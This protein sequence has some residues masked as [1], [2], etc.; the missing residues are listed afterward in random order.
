MSTART[1]TENLLAET[2]DVERERGPEGFGPHE[3]NMQRANVTGMAGV[4]K[5]HRTPLTFILMNVWTFP[6]RRRKQN[7]P[8][9]P[10]G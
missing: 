7:C 5:P 6:E 1:L 8:R 9:K 4:P 3:M 10:S 2:V